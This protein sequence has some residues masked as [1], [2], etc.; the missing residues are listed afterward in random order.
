MKTLKTTTLCMALLGLAVL[1]VACNGGKANPTGNDS[2]G[3]PLAELASSDMDTM[4]SHKIVEKDRLMA[5]PIDSFIVGNFTGKGM[6]TLYI[7]DH[8]CAKPF[9]KYYEGEESIWDE[10]TEDYKMV[11]SK[12]REKYAELERCTVLSKSGNLPQLV[13]DNVYERRIVF[14]GDLDGN[15]TDEFGYFTLKHRYPIK[16]NDEYGCEKMGYSAYGVSELLN[17]VYHIVTFK[18]GK[19]QYMATI[20]DEY[21]EFNEG[22]IVQPSDSKEITAIHVRYME[23]NCGLWS[24]HDEDTDTTGSYQVEIKYKPIK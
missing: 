20:D 7:A 17:Y 19:W 14:E 15:G 16:L 21:R 4:Y 11:H 5:W 9:Y 6:D 12:G 1:L 23:G 3:N 18:D 8:C 13:L 2:E 10:K 24:D 22:L